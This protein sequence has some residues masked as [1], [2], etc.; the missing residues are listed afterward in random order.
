M[1]N[2]LA[3]LTVLVGFAPAG[4][5]DRVFVTNVGFQ[6]SR[7][8]TSG[9]TTVV[10]SGLADS[11]CAGGV[12]FAPV[13]QNYSVG[14]A[15]IPYRYGQQNL[16]VPQATYFFAASNPRVFEY[17]TREFIQV[18]GTRQVVTTDGFGNEVILNAGIRSSEVRLSRG[19]QIFGR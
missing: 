3:V 15:P 8:V 14:L 18:P 16:V 11:H 2:V 5:D 17:R 4:A 7:I 19:T 13:Q 1:R 9:S 10:Q 12:C 6:S